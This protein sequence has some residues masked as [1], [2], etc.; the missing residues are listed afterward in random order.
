[1]PRRCPQVEL[2]RRK[3]SSRHLTPLSSFLTGLKSRKCLIFRR[4]SRV[5]ILSCSTTKLGAQNAANFHEV[6]SRIPR[7][8]FT[9]TTRTTLEKAVRKR[10]ILN[11]A[12]FESISRV[13]PTRRLFNLSSRL[14]PCRRFFPSA[15]PRKVL[16]DS[17][18]QHMAVCLATEDLGMAKVGTFG[19]FCNYVQV[20]FG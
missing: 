14:L 18:F 9:R 2:N 16:E 19:G 7:I 10:G 1:V 8:L 17:L 15:T 11:I 4:I 13:L 3:V 6:C 5:M 20:E 12:D